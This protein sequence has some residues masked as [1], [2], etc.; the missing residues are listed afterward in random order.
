MAQKLIVQDPKVLCG[1][2][3]VRGTRISVELILERFADGWTEDQILDSYPNLTPES[4]RAAF[5]YA[6]EVLAKQSQVPVRRRA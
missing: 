4:L 1:K 2:P 6:A 3:T 5:A